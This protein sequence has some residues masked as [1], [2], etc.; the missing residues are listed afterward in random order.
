MAVGKPSFF[1]VY[2]AAFVHPGRAMAA[3]L[4]E[5]RR[6]RW[7][8]YSVA[9]IAAVYTLVYFF[10]S[11]NGG[12]PTVFAPW[13]AIPAE[14]YYRYNLVL[15]APSIVLAWISAGGTAQLTARAL[16]GHGSFE[17]TLAAQGLGIGVASWATGIHDVVTS[18]LGYIGSLDQRAYEDA[19]STP[20][21]GPHALIWS[22]MVVYLVAFLVLFIRGSAAAHRLRLARAVPVGLAGSVVYQGVFAIFNR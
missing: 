18:F 6:L 13:L 2:A 19:M 15:H 14:S 1:A 7:G 20:G 8:A 17:D 22:L 10:L 12:R 9:L 3:L 21:T 11:R 16:G 4:D 5:P